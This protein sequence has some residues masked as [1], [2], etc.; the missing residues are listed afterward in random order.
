MTRRRNISTRRSYT[1]LSAQTHA[2]LL[3]LI[4]AYDVPLDGP[5]FKRGGGGERPEVA[6]IGVA[7]GELA[8]FARNKTDMEQMALGFGPA[9]APAAVHPEGRTTR[10]KKYAGKTFAQILGMCAE[11]KECH[12][13]LAKALKEVLGVFK[14]PDA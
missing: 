4:N 11:G 2:H 12:N 8:T 13:D 1:S 3:G 6:V 9:K 7:L 14:P 10:D 5:D